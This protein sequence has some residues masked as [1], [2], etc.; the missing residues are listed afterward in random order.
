MA[1]A[2]LLFYAHGPVGGSV[3]LPRNKNDYALMGM[4]L[5]AVVREMCNQDE[6]VRAGHGLLGREGERGTYGDQQ[7]P[8]S[9]DRVAHQHLP[10]SG[11]L[12]SPK[13]SSEQQQTVGMLRRWEQAWGSAPC[14]LRLNT[15]TSTSGG[16]W[17]HCLLVSLRCV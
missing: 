5:K 10:V 4:S 2:G 7:R 1:G 16:S 9:S 6:A 3:D 13:A 8:D 17:L 14:G 15:L 11:A 12:H